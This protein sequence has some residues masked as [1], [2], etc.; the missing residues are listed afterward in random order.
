MCATPNNGWFSSLKPLCFCGASV[1]TAF[2]E[3]DWGNGEG[4]ATNERM[5]MRLGRKGKEVWRG[6]RVLGQKDGWAL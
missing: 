6:V 5:G 1:L 4:E 2:L 3:R